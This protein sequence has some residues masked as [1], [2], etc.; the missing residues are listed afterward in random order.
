MKRVFISKENGQVK[1]YTWKDIRQ[2]NPHLVYWVIF[3]QGIDHIYKDCVSHS[4]MMQT[5]NFKRAMRLFEKY[6]GAYVEKLVK[7]KLGRWSL[8]IYSNDLRSI[9]EIY[10]D[11]V[12]HSPIVFNHNCKI[13]N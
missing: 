2:S 5:N 12:T 4:F 10:D 6:K 1:K 8:T 7:C 11:Y 3:P 13:I 9:D